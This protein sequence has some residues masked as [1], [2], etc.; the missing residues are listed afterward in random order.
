MSPA[1]NAAGEAIADQP[2]VS[3]ELAAGI[4]GLPVR[5]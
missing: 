5:I 4:L 3:P 2:V 1:P